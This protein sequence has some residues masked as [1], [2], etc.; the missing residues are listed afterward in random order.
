MLIAVAILSCVLLVATAMGVSRIEARHAPRG[1][2]VE[3]ASGR[4][5]VLD[6]PARNGY[7]GATIVLLHGASG[8][9]AEIDLALGEALSEGHRVI[10]VDRPGHGWSDRPGGVADAS[11]A[12]QADLIRQALD[13]MD[14]DR[15]VIVGHSLAG[16]VAAN[17]ALDHADKV[18]G[19]VLLSA[20]THPWPGGVAL[21]NTV[22]SSP[23][24]GGPMVRTI[25]YPLGM[26]TMDKAVAKVFAPGVP[27]PDYVERASI[28]L[29]LR[30][31]QFRANAQDITNLKAFVTTQSS[32]Y[33]AI[34]IPATVITADEDHVVTPGIHSEAIAR[35]IAGAKLVVLPG[36]GHMPHHTATARVVAEIEEVVER[37]QK[38]SKAGR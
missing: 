22:A 13:R 7:P 25:V 29:L 1:T 11:P 20:V 30:P 2:F 37:A 18:S 8:G 27:P 35:Q 34:A 23:V 6:R 12:R 14:V 17:L 36:A 16:A 3:V 32:R 26:L 33:G 21:Q 38:G 31:R 15:A 19:L 24:L 10:A 28:P 9:L 5:H 4:L